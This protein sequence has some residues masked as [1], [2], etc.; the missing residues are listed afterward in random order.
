MKK[1]VGNTDKLIRFIIA[2]VAIWAAYMGLVESPW[3]YVLYAIAAI[4][5]LTA[6]TSTCPIWLMTGMNT[7]KSK[8]K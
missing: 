2:L 7:I 4:M 5:L 1:N 8:L 6:L 3:T